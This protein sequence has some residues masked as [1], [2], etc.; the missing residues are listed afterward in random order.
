ME[1][2]EA[3]KIL[4]QVIEW[5][6]E[7]I[8][9]RYDAEEL[10]Y[11]LDICFAASEQEVVT[12]VIDKI[13]DIYPLHGRIIRIKALMLAKEKRDQ[14]AIHLLSMVGDDD[15]YLFSCIELI[16]VIFTNNYQFKKGIQTFNV[17]LNKIEN[18]DAKAFILHYRAICYQY[19]GDYVSAFND[20]VN[21]AIQLFHEDNLFKEICLN[22]NLCI[23]NGKAGEIKEAL[24][25]FEISC[26]QI[27][28]EYCSF[29]ANHFLLELSFL[30][31]DL[32]SSKKYLLEC[33]EYCTERALDLQVRMDQ[34]DGFFILLDDYKQ[35]QSALDKI[36]NPKKTRQF[37][38]KKQ[39][40]Y[41]VKIKP[42]AMKLL[43]LEAAYKK[44]LCELESKLR[45][46][47][48]DDFNLHDALKG[49]II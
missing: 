47:S 3:R 24:K 14:D 4:I 17:L 10:G 49:I 23:L 20:S 37:L 31:G 15:D 16:G 33:K 29:G 9:K 12:N 40:D 30:R 18:A 19:L 36:A 2:E 8:I 39:N 28:E 42:E 27:N 5:E 25:S 11:A 44:Q 21:A 32:S 7:K 34:M 48:D 1:I 26:L 35:I 13:V 38:S 22:M 6:N 41:T 43:R 46:I 45:E